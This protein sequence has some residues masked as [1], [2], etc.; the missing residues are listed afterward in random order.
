MLAIPKGA[1]RTVAQVELLFLMFVMLGCNRNVRTMKTL[2]ID[3]DNLKVQHLSHFYRT[4]NLGF[5][6]QGACLGARE[7]VEV[8]GR[9]GFSLC[10]GCGFNATENLEAYFYIFKIP[11]NLKSGNKNKYLQ[12]KYGNARAR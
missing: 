5:V 9:C 8:F 10:F 11:S 4:N 3:S 1:T 6:P 7:H 2:N 12:T